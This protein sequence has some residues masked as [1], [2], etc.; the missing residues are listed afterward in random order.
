[1]IGLRASRDKAPFSPDPRN[2]ISLLSE[3]LPIRFCQRV[4]VGEPKEGGC[5]A[6]ML[7]TR[8]RKDVERG[9]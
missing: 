9:R 7:G 6:G 3:I 5:E 8:G 2:I 4:N 1:M